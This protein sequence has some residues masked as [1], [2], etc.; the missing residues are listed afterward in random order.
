MKKLVKLLS[1]VTMAAAGAFAL[2]NVSNKSNNKVESAEAAAQTITDSTLEIRFTRS[3]DWGNNGIRIHT[4]N[5]GGSG[6]SWPG[7]LMTWL[8]NNEFGQSVFSWSPSASEPLYGNIIFNN[9]N[10]GMQTATLSAPS[11]SK[12]YWYDNGWQSSDAPTMDIYLYDYDNRFNGNV[13]AH[14][15]RDNG[16]GGAVWNGDNWPGAAMTRLTSVA[17]NGLIYKLTM[18]NR[19][20]R[21]IFSA[22]GNNQTGTL[23]PAGNYCYVLADNATSLDGKNTWWDNINY[24]LAHNFAENTMLLRSVPT[25]DQSSTAY[26]SSRYSAAS[27]HWNALDSSGYLEYVLPQLQSGFPNALERFEK[28]AI[29]NGHSFNG[30]TGVLSAQKVFLNPL[31]ENN[32]SVMIIVI[33]SLVSVTAIGGF[34]FI[35]R[36]KETN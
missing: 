30:E 12:A 21:V 18:N 24:V 8:W 2:V 25:S 17:T 13:N 23:T 19:Y 9:D 10:H 33:I 28:W 27:A 4:W 35:R 5:E 29:A 6:T 26:C 15:W 14:I 20:D 32:A 1:I 34:F 22:N 3:S 36:R 16:S 7:Y 31:S 11:T